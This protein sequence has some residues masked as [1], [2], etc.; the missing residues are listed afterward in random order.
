M[1]E[2][3]NILDGNGKIKWDTTYTPIGLEINHL[4][5]WRE[6]HR[7]ELIGATAA[8]FLNQ[9]KTAWAVNLI[10]PIPPSD[11]TRE[12][13]PVYEIVSHIGRICNIPVN[14]QILKKLKT[15][16]QL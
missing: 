10:I 2:G 13:Q 3:N 15:T 4:K 9:K 7:A 16:S 6:R 14:Y 11:T 1:A 8:N 12:F 5:Y